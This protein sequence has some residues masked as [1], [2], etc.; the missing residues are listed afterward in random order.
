SSSTFTFKGDGNSAS[1]ESDTSKGDTVNFSSDFLSFNNVLEK[2]FAL[3]FSSLKPKLSLDKNKWLNS[4]TTSG[5]GT[6]AAEFVPD[7][8]SLSL[9]SGGLL[10]LAGF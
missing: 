6:F 1:T 7:G 2:D 3:S 10:P 4:F 8:T 5:T 9:L